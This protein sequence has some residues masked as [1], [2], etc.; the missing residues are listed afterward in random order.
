MFSLTANNEKHPTFRNY[1]SLYESD[2]LT[3]QK[4]GGKKN[5]K[6]FVSIK[7][8]KN[9]VRGD[10]R[11]TNA[12]MEEQW[13]NRW[14]ILSSQHNHMLHPSFREYFDSPPEST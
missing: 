6:A 3:L 2:A 11:F 4:I 12:D 1:F 8:H 14:H 9:P 13:A 10:P 5:N 7:Q